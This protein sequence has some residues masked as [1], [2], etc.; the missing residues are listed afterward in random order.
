M[1]EGSVLEEPK[2]LEFVPNQY[3]NQEKCDEVF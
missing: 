3:K 2:A 1:C